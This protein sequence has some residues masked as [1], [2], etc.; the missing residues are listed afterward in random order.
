MSDP[1][2]PGSALPTLIII[3][4]A[5]CG[6]TSLHHYL[7]QHP[8]IG[9]SEPKEPQHFVA[10]DWRETL[11]RY[12][13]LFAGMPFKVR[14]ES[15]TMYSKFPLWEDIP[16]RI[17]QTI[18]EVKLIY[19]VGHPV[20]RIVSQ[21]VEAF[22][23]LREYRG[24]EGVLRDWDQ[25]ANSYVAPSRYG[26]QLS[27]YLEFFRRE[28]ILVID[29]ERMRSQRRETLREVLRFLEVD[30]E[31]PLASDAEHNVGSGKQRLTPQAARLW[32]PVI[33]PATRRLPSWIA[34]R[35]AS[36]I[37]RRLPR[38]PVVRPRLREELS[39]GLHR[40]LRDE[41]A[42]LESLTGQSFDW[43]LE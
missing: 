10:A 7:D 29:Q 35:V 41:V 12:E 42:L 22:S 38:E 5:K 14:G 18:P 40:T 20:R 39:E 19:V 21:Y 13:R 2:R 31:I 34:D 15:S 9:M 1:G 28:S 16:G 11:P 17:H 24:L 4:A 6:T 36:A 8:E 43:P 37:E 23:G 3:G 25:P 27:R 32:F 30:P 26:T 33:A